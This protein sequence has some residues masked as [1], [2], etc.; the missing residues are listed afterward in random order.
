MGSPTTKSA[1]DGIFPVY[2]NTC[3]SD[4]GKVAELPE[5]G[6][7]TTEK[8]AVRQTESDLSLSLVMINL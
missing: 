3:S 8:V 5:P 6:A 1:P 2:D 7:P 4:E